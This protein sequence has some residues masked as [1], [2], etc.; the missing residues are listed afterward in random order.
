M[1]TRLLYDAFHH[2]PPG[3]RVGDEIVTGA[4]HLNTGRYAPGD[5]YH[6]NG[7]AML[8]ACLA[9]EFELHLLHAPYSRASL[10]DADVLLITNP[11][12]PL[13]DGAS[14]YRWTDAE[15][16]ALLEFAER[17]G[18]V[19]LT[20][21][22]FLSRPYFWEENFDLERVGLLFDRL[23]VRW[24]ANFMSNED[25]LEQAQAGEYCLAYGQ[26]GRVA[27][28]RWSK[29]LRPLVTRDENVYG[30]EAAVGRGKIAVLGDSGLISNGLL[31]F[32]GFDNRAFVTG[33]LHS[34]RPAWCTEGHATWDRCVWRHIST[35]AID[36]ILSE[37]EIRNLRPAATWSKDYH[38]R[39]LTWH[40]PST[41][42]HRAEVWNE[43]PL[44]LAKAKAR[45]TLPVQLP[46][47]LVDSDEPGLPVEMELQV[48]A[49][50]NAEGCDLHLL[51]YR[52][53]DELP[54]GAVCRDAKS[55]P[56]FEK[57]ARRST[58]FELWAVLNS[59]GAPTRAHWRQGHRLY[60]G[61]PNISHG[62]AALLMS[63]SGVICP[64]A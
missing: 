55:L 42:A 43:L 54:L 25:H 31:C 32:P 14:P 60:L 5:C 16:D 61:H 24:D 13:Y 38:Y 39:H 19:L 50:G 4:Y 20:V 34:L 9:E 6:P 53:D 23:G 56:G 58:T 10:F 63:R 47:L 40:E 18:G 26:G 44:D 49:R 45:S 2:M 11:D 27:E 21:N 51:G 41:R 12:Y 1:K 37:D 7:L 48:H 15:V 33:L 35:T 57:V 8:E 62:Y 22:S 59:D 30:F 28:G 29:N 36:T 3:H 64:R 52:N 46:A 17:G